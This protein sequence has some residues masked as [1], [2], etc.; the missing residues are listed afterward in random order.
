MTFVINKT[1]SGI[2]FEKAKEKTVENLKSEGFGI[3][4]EIDIQATMKNK[5]GKEYRPFVI[6]GAC[7]PNYADKVLGID[8]HISAFLPC[9]VTVRTLEDGNIEVAA[10]DP[11]AAMGGIGIPEV[12]PFARDVYEKLKRVINSL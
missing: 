9:N 12:E 11:I 4:T 3:L 10:V 5:L 7:N 2:S 6:L 1:L 8:P